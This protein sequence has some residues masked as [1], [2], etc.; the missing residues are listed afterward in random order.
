MDI[1][2]FPDELHDEVFYVEN[3]ERLPD[4][5][6]ARVDYNAALF[7]QSGRLRV[8]IGEGQQVEVHKGQLMLVP[9]NKL[10]RNMMVNTDLKM[11][12]MFVSDRV[13]TSVL[14]PQINIWN[15]AMY[16]NQTHIVNGEWVESMKIFAQQLSTAEHLKLKKELLLSFLRTV[17]LLVCEDLLHQGG[18]LPDEATDRDKGVFNNFLKLLAAQQQK[19]RQVSFYAS[20]LCITPKY[21][22]TVCK[23]VSGKSPRQ[24]ITESVMEDIFLLLKEK[25]LNIKQVS[26][27]LG[28]PNASF[29]G[30]FFREQ[31]G[32]TPADYRAKHYQRY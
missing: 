27:R 2:R 24:W 16:L 4:E 6:A 10:V 11:G 12:A 17:L 18:E 15:Q 14:G 19:H 1:L 20:E 7:C 28:F 5:A 8:E 25:D 29:F 26:D 30:Q 22:S 23:R 13:L 32:E 9:S 21:L 3:I 31:T